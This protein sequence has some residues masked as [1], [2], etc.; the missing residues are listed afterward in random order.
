MPLEWSGSYHVAMS[1]SSNSFNTSWMA[2]SD[3]EEI[4]DWIGEQGLE[5]FELKSLTATTAPNTEYHPK[6]GDQIEAWRTYYV[7]VV[8]RPTA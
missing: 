6:T 8:Q 3:L 2:G 7:A 5:G 4:L 1:K